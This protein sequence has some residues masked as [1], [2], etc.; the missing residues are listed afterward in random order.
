MIS[1]NVKLYYYFTD[2]N[3]QK[4]EILANQINSNKIIFDVNASIIENVEEIEE[5]SSS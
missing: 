2:N 5:I 3:N 4:N 1:K